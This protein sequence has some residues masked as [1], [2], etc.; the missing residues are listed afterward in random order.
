M[1]VW[2]W[3]GSISSASSS[4][5]DFVIVCF[6]VWVG[7]LGLTLLQVTPLSCLLVV[8]FACLFVFV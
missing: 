5:F 4:I 2:V 3:C 8:C 7:V 6:H 1:W